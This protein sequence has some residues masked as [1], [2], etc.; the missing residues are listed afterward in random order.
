MFPAACRWAD[1]ICTTSAPATWRAPT[2]SR[3]TVGLKYKPTVEYGSRRLLGSAP[4]LARDI[5]DDRI[6]ADL[7]PCGTNS[8]PMRTR[9]RSGLSSR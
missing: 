1:S 3:E 9:D 4:D 5:L 7:V 6:T 2:L 8:L